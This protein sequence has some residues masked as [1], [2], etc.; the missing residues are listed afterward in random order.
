LALVKWILSLAIFAEIWVHFPAS[1]T[2]IGGIFVFF[3]WTEAGVSCEGSDGVTSWGS[4]GLGVGSVAVNGLQLDLWDFLLVIS[5]TSGIGLMGSAW[6]FLTDAK[7][8]Y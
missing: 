6:R 5:L 4:L 7:H 3:G 2:M 1:L 8:I